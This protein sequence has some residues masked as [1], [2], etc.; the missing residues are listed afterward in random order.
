MR[1]GQEELLKHPSREKGQNY[2]GT[3]QKF[4]PTKLRNEHASVCF[5]C[6]VASE[7]CLLSVFQSGGDVVTET[8]PHWGAKEELFVAIKP[9][10]YN[11]FNN[12]SS[13]AVTC[14]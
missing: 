12:L 14:C 3:I 7:E 6:T 1:K 2:K 4:F 11:G 9:L 13:Q 5:E 10:K 8:H